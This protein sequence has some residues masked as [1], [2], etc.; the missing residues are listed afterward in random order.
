MTVMLEKGFNYLLYEEKARITYEIVSELAKSG[1]PVLCITTVFPKKLRKMYPLEN[2]EILWLSDSGS[3]P[4]TLKPTRLDFEITRS[5]T[6]FFKN[7]EGAVVFLDGFEYLLSENGFDKARRFIKRI[8]DTASITDGTFI[9]CVNKDAIPKEDLITLSKDFDIVKDASELMEKSESAGGPQVKSHAPEPS[10]PEQTYTSQSSSPRPVPMS[11]LSIEK[12]MESAPTMPTGAGLPLEIEDIYLIHRN[13]GILLQ[14]KTWRDKDVIDPDL[15]AG[16]FQ[17][18][19][20]FV[21]ESFASGER[22]KFSRMDI[23]GYIIL[24]Y[25]SDLVSLAIVFAGEGEDVLYRSI[26]KI[27]TIMQETAESIEKAYRKDLEDYKGDVSVFKGTRKYLDYLALAIYDA[28]SAKPGEEVD[29]GPIMPEA[30]VQPEVVEAPIVTEAEDYMSKASMAARSGRYQEALKYFDEALRIQPNNLKALFNKA[31][32]LQMLGRHAEA[33]KYY[34][35]YLKINPYDPE[36][37]SNKGMALR[38]M[39]RVDEAIRCYEKGIDLNPEDATLW[40]NKGI[41]LRSMGRVDEAIKCYDRA[42]EIDP[43]DAGIWSNK[44]VALQSVG[45]LEEAIKCYDRAL[46]IDPHRRVPL[47]NREIA[48]RQLRQ[49]GLR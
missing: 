34:D 41:A 14:R 49:R 32:M 8:N 45:R 4:K 10:P 5:I 26:H 43:N 42:L 6:N 19:L 13:A 3:D 27:R 23:K 21:N 9:I 24:V 15:V 17:G 36:A 7:N 38:R 44:G 22:S 1:S 30:E 18:V 20:N 11:P 12:A 2:A 48:L 40:S 33:I 16:M 29:I 46:E 47:Q 25:D 37:W 31:V 28:M 39:G 35:E